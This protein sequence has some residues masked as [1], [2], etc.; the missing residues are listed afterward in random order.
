MAILR[1]KYVYTPSYIKDGDWR[2]N[3]K[4][5]IKDFTDFLIRNTDNECQNLI[6]NTYYKIFN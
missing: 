1:R 5:K 2:I 3:T 6:T 4:S